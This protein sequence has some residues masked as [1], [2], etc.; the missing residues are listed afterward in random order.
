MRAKYRLELIL[1]ASRP[2][3]TAKDTP[4]HSVSRETYPRAESPVRQTRGVTTLSAVPEEARLR[5]FAASTKGRRVAASDS[6]RM[7]HVKHTRTQQACSAHS[8]GRFGIEA[9]RA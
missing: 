3:G 7:F 8:P 5:R 1:S 6:S 9:V 4:P 2:A